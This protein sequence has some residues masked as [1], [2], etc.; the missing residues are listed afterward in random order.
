MKIK[1]TRRLEKL[2]GEEPLPCKEIG[3]G[4]ISYVKEYGDDAY[5]QEF[6]QRYEERMKDNL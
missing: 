4:I 5:I 2:L 3:S 6:A 1:Q